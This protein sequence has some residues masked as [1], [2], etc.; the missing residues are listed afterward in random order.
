MQAAQ[1]LAQAYTVIFKKPDVA[2]TMVDTPSIARLPNGRLLASNNI[3]GSW[4]GGIGQAGLDGVFPGGRNFYIHASDDDGETWRP[5]SRLKLADGMLLTL[6]DAVYVLGTGRE[7][8]VRRDVYITRSTDGGETWRELVQIHEGP[9]WNS[10]TGVVIRDGQLYRAYDTA[11]HQAD[12]QLFV[13]AGNL[14]RDLLDPGSWRCSNAVGFPGLPEAMKRPI[15]P[16]YRDH[17]LEANVVDIRGRLTVIARCRI[18][19][20][21]TCHLA[22]VCDLS[23]T[24]HDLKL[25]FTQFHPFPGGQQKFHILYDDV[26]DLYWMVGN[27]VTDPQDHTGRFPRLR[28]RGYRGGA[29]NERRILALFYSLDSLNWLQAGVV[30]MSKDPMQGFMYSQMLIDGDD[31]IFA[32][33]TSKAGGNNHDAE[34]VT[35][36]RLPHFRSQALDIHP[37]L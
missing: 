22:G 16:D 29:G 37:Q 32:V 14:S 20:F 7:G 3:D 35:F 23:D 17:W 13:L 8:G 12:R 10:A 6:D 15:N 24:E 30:A 2:G 1:P 18:D 11:T 9:A 19:D 4:G 34:L 21:G 26:S 27:L 25:E 5:L 28:E 31:L 36:H 33:R